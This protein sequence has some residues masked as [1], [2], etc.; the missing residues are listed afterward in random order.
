[1]FP[2]PRVQKPDDSI[3]AFP[4]RKL[5]QNSSRPYITIW[6]LVDNIHVD[7]LLALKNRSILLETWCTGLRIPTTTA[8]YH[9]DNIP[10]VLHKSEYCVIQA[11]M[12]NAILKLKS[13]E[14]NAKMTRPLKTSTD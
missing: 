5:T 13:S 9:K 6:N 2:F 14:K 12:S 11:S 7:I 8:D 1:M 10:T 4:A 3:P